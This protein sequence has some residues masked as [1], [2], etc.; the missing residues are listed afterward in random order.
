MYL[1]IFFILLCTLHTHRVPLE[2][3]GFV[4]LSPFPRMAPTGVFM[5]KSTSQSWEGSRCWTRGRAVCV[6]VPVPFDHHP[7]HSWE[8]CILVN[9]ALCVWA[10]S[11][12][13]WAYAIWFILGMWHGTAPRPALSGSPSNG[14]E[15]SCLGS[16]GAS[17]RKWLL[18]R[19]GRRK[20]GGQW[21]RAPGQRE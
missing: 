15:A 2:A 5:S 20:L 17:L 9:R 3:S 13:S 18:N 14:F 7:P 1:N 10:I 8:P 16:C 11:N 4:L 12:G 19:R 21:G 6:W